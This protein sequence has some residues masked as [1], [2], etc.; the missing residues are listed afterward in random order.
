MKRTKLFCL[1]CLSAVLVN[2]SCS[3][4]D[5]D[6]N[7]DNKPVVTPV[8]DE[9][10]AADLKET[11][12]YYFYG[13]ELYSKETFTYGKFEAKMKMAYAPGCISSM[14]LY[15][16]DSYKGGT[17]VWNEIDIE[18]IGKQ[19]NGFQSNII[20]GK[21]EKKV[22]SENMYTTSS[23]ISNDFHI[24][25]IE[26]TPEYVAWYFDG[27]EVRRNDASNDSKKQVEAL[28]KDQ[29][30]RFNIWSSKSVDWVGNLYQ[31][32]IPITQEIDY[33]KVYNYDAASKTFTENW[34]DDFNSS[35]DTKR[36]GTGNWQM[37]NVVERP[38]NVVVEDGML[39]LML[40]KEKK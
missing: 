8:V 11:S 31:K 2:T 13:A 26:W 24:Y 14:F 4:D 22:T 33:V 9:Y 28:V 32:N 5:D 30:L 21:S 27:V 1:L 7:S 23:P 34:T 29:S 16:N 35:L 3:K 18:V 6:D 38:K 25:T 12:N 19:P 37:E 40:T 10:D 15:Y 36:W 39:K 17:E 20:T